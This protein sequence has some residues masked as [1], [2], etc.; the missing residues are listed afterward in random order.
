[1]ATSNYGVTSVIQPPTLKTVDQPALIRFETAYAAY[2][3]KLEDVNKDRHEPSKLSP[4]TVKDCMNSSTLH[5]LC[6]MKEIETSCT[7]EDAT[8]EMVKKW[9]ENASTSTPKD[10]SK[11]IDA[12]LRSISF[13]PNKEDPAGGVANFMIEAITALDQNNASELLLD[14]D[15]AK[16][17][18]DRLVPK[19]KPDV[20]Q[21]RLKMLRRGWTKGQLADIKLFKDEVS[22]VALEISLTE[23]ALSRVRP[24][25]PRQHHDSSKKHDGSPTSRSTTHT[26]SNSDSRNSGPTRKRKEN[27]EKV[28][29]MKQSCA[30]NAYREDANAGRFKVSLEDTVFDVLLGDSGADFSAIDITLFQD[31]ISRNPRLPAKRVNNPLQLAD[32]F[33]TDDGTTVFSSRSVILTITIYLPGSNIPVEAQVRAVPRDW[34]RAVKLAVGDQVV[35]TTK[36]TQTPPRRVWVLVGAAR[37]QPTTKGVSELTGCH[38]NRRA[39]KMADPVKGRAEPEEGYRYRAQ[40]VPVEIDGKDLVQEYRL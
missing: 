34:C 30:T 35:F 28:K 7:V 3:A 12:T 19:F 5:A 33:N 2:R 21:E 10:L 8:S 39:S 24:Q 15:M 14:G 9:F 32:A 23:T 17:S 13:K 40:C 16:N 20:L 26:K 36:R 6:I 29:T 37:A 22:N 25:K 27:C 31:M 1:M 38:P 18:I 4:A 11:R